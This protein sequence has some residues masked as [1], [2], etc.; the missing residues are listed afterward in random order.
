MDTLRRF[1]ITIFGLAFGVFLSIL[2]MMKGWGLEIES[3]GWVIGIGFFGQVFAQVIIRIGLH[4][5]D[6]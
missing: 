3:W 2:T 5:G 1:M 6:E 4:P